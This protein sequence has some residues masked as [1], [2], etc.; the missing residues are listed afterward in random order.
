MKWV[1]YC[2]DVMKLTQYFGWKGN[3]K[4]KG[5]MV[6]TSVYEWEKKLNL[7]DKYREILASNKDRK[8]Y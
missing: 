8:I 1:E 3:C 7:R 5:K 2:G 4:I 6:S